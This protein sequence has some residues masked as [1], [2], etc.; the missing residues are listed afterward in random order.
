[1]GPEVP[2]TLSTY[3]GVSSICFI[4]VHCDVKSDLE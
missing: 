1:M 4:L 2:E 3:E